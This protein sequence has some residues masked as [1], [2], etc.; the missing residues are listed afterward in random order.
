M[1]PDNGSMFA[2]SSAYMYTNA[3]YSFAGDEYSLM[4]N[5]VSRLHVNG[6]AIWENPRPLLDPRFRATILIKQELSIHQM[7][8]HVS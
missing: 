6:I 3:A 7:K 5:K 4:F 8:K 1:K 2:K